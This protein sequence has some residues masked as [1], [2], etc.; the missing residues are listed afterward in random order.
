MKIRCSIVTLAIGA[1]LAL[2]SVAQADPWGQDRQG[3]RSQQTSKVFAVNHSTK[4]AQKA[5]RL[6]AQ[7]TAVADFWRVHGAG[8]VAPEGVYTSAPETGRACGY[9][10]WC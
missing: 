7:Q 6:R 8:G 1:T 9:R 4:Q 2:A 3:D 10:D 5:A